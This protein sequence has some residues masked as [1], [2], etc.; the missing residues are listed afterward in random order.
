MERSAFVAMVPRY[1]IQFE[2]ILGFRAVMSLKF[3]RES[4]LIQYQLDI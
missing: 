1:G 3:L 2:M 4:I